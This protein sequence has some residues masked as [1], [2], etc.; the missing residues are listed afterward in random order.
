MHQNING[1]LYAYICEYYQA[2]LAKI[3]SDL[4]LQLNERKT[5]TFST[6]HVF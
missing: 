6:L 3:G 2:V 1:Q 5:M 4:P